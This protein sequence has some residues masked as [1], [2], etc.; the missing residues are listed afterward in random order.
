MG[1]KV[2]STL[3]TKAGLGFRD[4]LALPG[5][6]WMQDRC[7]EKAYI[8]LIHLAVIKARS[9]TILNDKVLRSVSFTG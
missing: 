3:G 1:E 4:T 5:A 8:S 7:T 6:N 2:P 9:N